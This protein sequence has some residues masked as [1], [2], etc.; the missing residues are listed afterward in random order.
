MTHAAKVQAAIE[1]Y[2]SAETLSHTNTPLCCSIFLRNFETLHPPALSLNFKH[3]TWIC[4]ALTLITTIIKSNHNLKTKFIPSKNPR[5]CL[6]NSPPW[7]CC[8][9][10]IWVYCILATNY[11]W[12]IQLVSCTFYFGSKPKGSKLWETPITKTCLLHGCLE[13][14]SSKNR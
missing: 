2:I 6:L 10:W 13:K 12:F 4:L 7:L 5:F 9:C 1:S 3:H 14:P 11:K 8:S